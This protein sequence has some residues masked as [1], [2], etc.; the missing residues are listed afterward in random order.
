MS[1]VEQNWFLAEPEVVAVAVAVAEPVVVVTVAIDANL[2]LVANVAE[3]WT[4][5]A[6]SH[7]SN[8]VNTGNHMKCQMC[9]RHALIFHQ[10][11]WIFHLWD[12][13]L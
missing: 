7:N 3:S 6:R 10:I 4:C 5:A 13:I 9:K 11:L 8:L 2:N 12:G 1:S